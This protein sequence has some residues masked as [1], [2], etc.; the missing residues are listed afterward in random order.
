MRSPGGRGRVGVRC[1]SNRRRPR[2]H[3]ARAGRDQGARH[4]LPESPCGPPGRC[5]TRAT[6]APRSHPPRSCSGQG[7]ASGSP[8]ICLP[9][10]PPPVPELAGAA[11]ERPGG[12]SGSP[13]GA[14]ILASVVPVETP[15]TVEVAP[16]P[17]MAAKPIMPPVAAAIV[18]ARRI[19][20]ASGR[21]RN[22]DGSRTAGNGAAR[23]TSAGNGPA[24]RA[25]S[26]TRRAPRRAP[27]RPP[28]GGSRPAGR[29]KPPIW[30]GWR[31]KFFSCDLPWCCS[32]PTT[33]CWMPSCLVNARAR[34]WLTSGLLAARVH[35]PQPKGPAID[36]PRPKPVR[37]IRMLSRRQSILGASA[38]ASLLTLPALA[39]T[40]ADRRTGRVRAGD[41]GPRRSS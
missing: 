35:S 13:P 1:R 37:A 14:R 27:A 19:G 10:R 41:R 38:A 32:H 26:R 7:F 4:R 28:P 40:G 5:A 3:G 24:A 11:V 20:P 6:R 8:S 29:R 23:S 9:K 17:E 25:V 15:V 31:G 34:A 30:P 12:N 39:Q 22:D 18:E 21:S 36:A 33:P 16:V 2:V